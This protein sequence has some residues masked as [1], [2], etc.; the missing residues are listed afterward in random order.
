MFPYSPIDIRLTEMLAVIT[1]AIKEK[2]G[3][4]DI[5][6]MGL[7]WRTSVGKT[8]RAHESRHIPATHGTSAMAFVQ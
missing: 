1:F 3:L 7:K 5:D 6:Q 4:I 2:S 8:E